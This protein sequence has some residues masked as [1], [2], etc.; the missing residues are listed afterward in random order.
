MIL[1][2]MCPVFIQRRSQALP[3][4]VDQEGD[5][6]ESMQMTALSDSPIVPSS[7]LLQPSQQSQTPRGRHIAFLVSTWGPPLLVGLWVT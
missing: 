3:G 5:R 1:Y 4:G 7:K 2:K 6:L